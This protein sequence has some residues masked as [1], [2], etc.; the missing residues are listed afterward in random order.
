MISSKF[1]YKAL[2]PLTRDDCYYKYYSAKKEDDKTEKK[3]V[4]L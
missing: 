3:F 4:I 1:P 2:F